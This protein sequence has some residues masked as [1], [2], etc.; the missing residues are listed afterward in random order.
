VDYTHADLGGPGTL[1]A[2]Q[3]AQATS[4]QPADPALFGPNAPKIKG[5]IDLVGD[6]Y[7][8][9]S[10]DPARDVRHP[11]PNPLDCAGHGSH[12]S[13]TVAGF[14]VTGAGETFRGPWDKSVDGL[15]IGPGV[16]PGADLYAVRV[17]GC[18]GSTDAV[19]DAPEWAMRNEMNVVNMSLGS[20]FGI[21][22][23]ASAEAA[24][25][26]AESGIVVVASAGN[27]GP[28]PY[29]TGSPATSTSWLSV[30]AIDAV[31]SFG[32]ARLALGHRT[33]RHRA[34]R[35]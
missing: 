35:Q 3:A 26:A 16:A 20:S 21:A 32:A 8:A 4:T 1:A 24:E 19:V 33:G 27:S 22:Q 11:D 14:G 31:P 34:G 30:A 29:I 18:Q 13:G 9:A 6:D 7:N 25:A 15:R 12:V 5:G 10:A 28:A 2:W 17:F 23:D